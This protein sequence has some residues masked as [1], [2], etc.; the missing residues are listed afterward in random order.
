VESQGTTLPDRKVASA[1]GYWIGI[2]VPVLAAKV[3]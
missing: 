1:D 3:L 2:E